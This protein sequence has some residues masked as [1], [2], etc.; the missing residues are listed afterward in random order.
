MADIYDNDGENECSILLLSSGGRT[1][2]AQWKG[3]QSSQLR[4]VLVGPPKMPLSAISADMLRWT[5][6]PVSEF[7]AL[8]LRA[9]DWGPGLS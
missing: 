1:S 6:A 7:G 2:A 9:W 3:C 4:A 5:V 8:T